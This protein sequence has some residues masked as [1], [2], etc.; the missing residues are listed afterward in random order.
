[1]RTHLWRAV[2]WPVAFGLFLVVWCAGNPR[3]A[4]NQLGAAPADGKVMVA[5]V[6]YQ[7]WDNNVRLGNGQA[8]VIITLDVGPRIIS[9]RLADG[10]N[11]FKEYADQLGKSGE[12]EWMIRGGHRLW[13][14]PED[15]IRTYVPDNGPVT[16]QELDGGTARVTHQDTKHGLIKEMDVTLAPTGSR[17]TVTHRLTNSG[18]QPTEAAI[19]ALSVM[20]PGGVEVIPLAPKRPHPGGPKTAKSAADFAPNQTFALW[21]YFEFTDPRWH[22]GDKYI[23]LKQQAGKG[24]TKL[25]MSQKQGWVAYL[26]GGNLFVK[27]FPYLDGK[28]YPDGGSNYETFTNADMLELETLSPLVRLRPNQTIEHTEIWELFSGVPPFQNEADIDK[29]I[30]PRGA[31]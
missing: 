30:A 6:P 25:G 29:H 8:E 23:T 15:P 22:F 19:W 2:P 16:F 13:V 9:Y 31:Q 12:S 7:G 27:R 18:S 1:M 3:S 10:K 11:V 20:A 14:S 26:N 5:K 17:V 4:P 21:P 24:P 28:T